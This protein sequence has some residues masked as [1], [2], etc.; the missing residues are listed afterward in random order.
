MNR[1]IEQQSIPQPQSI[2]HR[3]PNQSYPNTNS[4]VQRN[5][6]VPMPHYTHTQL[7]PTNIPSQIPTS[8]LPINQHPQPQML[9][10]LP[11]QR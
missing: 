4:Q 9:V 7:I 10:N 1:P 6:Y 8:L 2:N 3:L 5:A 11:N